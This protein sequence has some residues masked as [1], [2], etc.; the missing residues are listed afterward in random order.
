MIF[1]RIEVAVLVAL[2]TAGGAASA[3]CNAMPGVG[4]AP[5]ELLVK[6]AV[7]HSAAVF[8]GKV[9]AIQY[10]PSSDP[11]AI[12]I[13][14]QVVR[15]STGVWWKGVQSKEVTL[16]TANARDA[17]GMTGTEAH[18]YPYEVGKS[19]LI[20]AYKSGD[21]LHADICTRTQTI[22]EAGGEIPVLDALK[23]QLA[24]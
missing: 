4:A 1:R 15:V 21:G 16:Q 12:G 7:A 8:V 9:T 5:L 17:A 2:A 24:G 22:G 11:A 10:I 19:Y 23:A 13:E 6:H 18:E 3:A 20:Y 14:N